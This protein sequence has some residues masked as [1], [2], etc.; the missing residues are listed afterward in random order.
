M[1]TGNSHPLETI[2]KCVSQS[3]DINLNTG[4][5]Y[6]KCIKKIKPEVE[7]VRHGA[8][9]NKQT[10][11]KLEGPIINESQEQIQNNIKE[12]PMNFKTRILEE[13]FGE[14][15]KEKL[16]QLKDG[17]INFVKNNPYVG[18]GLGGAALGTAMNYFGDGAQHLADDRTQDL[19]DWLKT[20]AREE[21]ADKATLDKDTVTDVRDAAIQL[22]H[23]N[24]S[25]GGLFPNPF[26]WLTGNVEDAHPFRTDEEAIN[27]IKQ[28]QLVNPEIKVDYLPKDFRG[29]SQPIGST[30]MEI[31][32]HKFN[33][34]SG[35]DADY[36][37]Y[38]NTVKEK[39][40]DMSEKD[41][42]SKIDSTPDLAKEQAQQV[43]DIGNSTRD[44]YL[45]KAL[46]GA[47]LGMGGLFA[48]RKLDERRNGG[49]Y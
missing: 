14:S 43:A 45:R 40:L 44:S 29:S 4:R 2:S 17:S 23:Q 19:K 18:L 7:C 48:K 9:P 27:L 33:L 22:T 13:N 1:K 35:S 28:A 31:G 24:D 39:F 25:A 46:G 20:D 8:N 41:I 30:N 38:E 6:I 21:L 12:Y 32:G 42:Q 16:G 15:V 34:F 26:P 36:N 5:Q 49:N 3:E 10:E 47:A 37:R 11:E